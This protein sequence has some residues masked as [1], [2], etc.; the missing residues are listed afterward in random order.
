MSFAWPMALLLI[1]FV[2]LLLGLY[3]WQLRRKRRMALRFSSV[4]LL[5]AAMPK[6]SRWRRVLPMALFL[7]GLGGLAVATARPQTSVTVRIGRTV[8]ILAL[9]VS[10]SMC[11]T[12]VPPNRISVA[13]AAARTF[14][15]DQPKGTRIGIV[16]FAGFA[17]L[18]V[19]P[20]T[21]KQSL[22]K[23]IDGLATSRGTAIGAAMLKSIDA[24]AA[25]NPAVRPVHSESDAIADAVPTAVPAGAPA[26][27]GIGPKGAYASD[28]VVVLTDGANT[29]GVEPLEA[30]K[31]AIDRGVR[32]YTIG[33]GTTNPTGLVCTAEQLGGDAF[34]S[35]FGGRSGGFPSG[36][37]AFLGGGRGGNARPF[38]VIDEPTLKEVA[39]R[40]GGAYYRAKDAGQL[41]KV[42]AK[43]PK[44]VVLQQKH[45]EISS[46]FAAVGAL[47]VGAAIM[48]SLRWNR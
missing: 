12:D 34:S 3:F 10:R 1:L 7:T 48:L 20:S 41:R 46:G 29:Q 36:G 4:A 31:Q 6:R 43:L 28:I 38:L 42:F 21:D 18:V 44:D 11:A 9:D 40:T 17:E 45:A 22:L 27:A 8:I 15:K 33:F 5:R 14:V 47:L 23:A 39:A 30:A 25:V 24:I 2:P 13:Q 19:E 26:K 37:G 35:G 32:V 16:A